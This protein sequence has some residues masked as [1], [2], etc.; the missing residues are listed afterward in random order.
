MSS[1][2]GLA[3]QTAL[4]T[5]DGRGM[6]DSTALDQPAVTIAEAAR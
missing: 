6:G 5:G 1:N 2:F 4:I 3:G